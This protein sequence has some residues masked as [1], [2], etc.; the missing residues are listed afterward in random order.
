MHNVTAEWR[1]SFGYIGEIMWIKLLNIKKGIEHNYRIIPMKDD[2]YTDDKLT[3]NKDSIWSFWTHEDE[4]HRD[5][6]PAIYS[7]LPRFM[8][9]WYNHGKLHKKY[10]PAIIKS[11]IAV[12]NRYRTNNEKRGYMKYEMEIMIDGKISSCRYISDCE[13]ENYFENRNI[14]TSLPL[15]F[16]KWCVNDR[17]ITEEIKKMTMDGKLKSNFLEWDKI[18][19]AKFNL[20]F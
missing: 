11:F 6:G 15:Y 10:E 19:R 9:W 13:Y 7:N 8:Y 20:K 1:D 16:C 3:L 2:F 18:D 12:S 4:I 17:D 14:Q 5:E